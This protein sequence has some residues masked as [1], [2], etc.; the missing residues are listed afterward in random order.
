MTL[1]QAIKKYDIKS[2]GN[3]KRKKDK[4]D[5]AN[6]KNFCGTKD[7]IKEVKINHKTRRNI[8]K[9]YS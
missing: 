1:N 5:F 3:N 7:T 4:L 8:Y 6:M 9:L 2:T